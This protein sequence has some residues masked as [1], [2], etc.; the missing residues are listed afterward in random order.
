MMVFTVVSLGWGVGEY[1]V[2]IWG[3]GAIPKQHLVFV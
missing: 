2:G 3:T 1:C